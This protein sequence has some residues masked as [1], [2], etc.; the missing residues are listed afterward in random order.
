MEAE[1]QSSWPA[2]LP[3]EIR[4]ARTHFAIFGDISGRNSIL[5]KSEATPLELLGEYPLEAIEVSPRSWTRYLLD[6]C[7]SASG[8]L[9]HWVI[10]SPL[11]PQDDTHGIGKLV[12]VWEGISSD[13]E[14]TEV[15]EV[16]D[17]SASDICA[18]VHG[19]DLSRAMIAVAPVVAECAKAHNRNRKIQFF[20]WTLAV[21]LIIIIFRR[22]I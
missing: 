19:G 5:V 9:Y 3:L 18:A 15:K 17:R 10:S 21:I 1:A 12:L 8:M 20:V 11:R 4:Y 13:K 16:L 7:T 6:L 2:S 22:G 14:R